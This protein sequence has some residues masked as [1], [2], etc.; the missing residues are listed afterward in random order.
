M[1]ALHAKSCCCYDCTPGFPAEAARVYKDDRSLFP[2]LRTERRRQQCKL[3]D[4]TYREKTGWPKRSREHL[5][6][7]DQAYRNRKRSQG[8][9]P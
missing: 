9:A 5:R 4:I 6:A 2:A 8:V 3:A 1:T 7:L